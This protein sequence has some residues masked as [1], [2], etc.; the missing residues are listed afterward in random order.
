[1]LCK[2]MGANPIGPVILCIISTQVAFFT[3]L[4]TP[5]VPV[6]MGVGNY[7]MKDL[8]KMGI[9]PFIVVPVVCVGWIMTVF[10]IV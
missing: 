5:V 3:P 8:L 10:P 9:L 7:T 2:S 1:M 6:M 4:A